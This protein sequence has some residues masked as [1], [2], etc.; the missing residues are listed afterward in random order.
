MQRSVSR[1]KAQTRYAAL[2]AAAG[3]LAL[4]KRSESLDNKFWSFQF[5]LSDLVG[6]KIAIKADWVVRS[7]HSSDRVIVIVRRGSFN[8]QPQPLSLYPILFGMCD[9][10]TDKPADSGF[11]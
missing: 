6:R 9:G 4:R 2:L 7:N 5:T 10:R 11:I 1:Y 8:A 3:F